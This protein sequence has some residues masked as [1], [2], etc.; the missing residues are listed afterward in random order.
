MA[1]ALLLLHLLGLF[2]SFPTASGLLF[3][4]PSGFRAAVY[5]HRCERPERTLVNRTRAVS[6]MMK[7]VN[8]YRQQ[9]AIAS[10]QGAQIIVFPEDGIY[11]TPFSRSRIRPY[12]EH[13]PDPATTSPPWI[14]CTHPDRFTP[15]DILSHL[16]CIARDNHV[17]VVA[18]LGDIQPCV[19]TDNSKDAKTSPC[20]DY[21]H[22][23]YNTDVAF[24]PQGT[25]VARYHKRDLF[26]ERQFDTPDVE[27]SIFDTP[28]GRFGLFT[29][30]DILFYEPAVTL[31][32]RGV[33]NV[34][35]PTAWINGHFPMHGAVQLHSAWARGLGVN[36][37]AA[38]YHWPEHAF[39]GSG[40]FTPE[41][42]VG[43]FYNTTTGSSGHLVVADVAPVS[44]PRTLSAAS[45]YTDDLTFETPPV[46]EKRIEHQVYSMVEIVKGSGN[47]SVCKGDTCCRLQYQRDAASSELFALGVFEGIMREQIDWYFEACLLMRCTNGSH[48]SCGEESEESR[49]NPPSPSCGDSNSRQLCKNARVASRFVGKFS[50]KYVYPE[51]IVSDGGQLALTPR[52]QWDFTQGGSLQARNISKPLL[53]AALYARV[54]TRDPQ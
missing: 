13:I 50:T 26:G 52:D 35:F 47:A 39:V 54:Y 19:S 46:F 43:Y 25:L 23:Q 48:S 16:S 12:L 27:Y 44:S 18:N 21:G 3:E 17:Y 22:F 24:D 15:S 20:P 11:G 33:T 36:L 34:A 4:Q 9:A 51:V 42:P 32:E 49:P 6:N 41:G 37:L 14:P 30:F 2:S 5:E 7:N 38:N 40:I 10:S 29:C 53:A 31:V 1:A 45:D 28:F 8:V